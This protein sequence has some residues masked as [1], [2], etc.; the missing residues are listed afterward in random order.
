MAQALRALTLWL[1]VLPVL[2]I[3]FLTGGVGR[4]DAMSAATVELCG[5]L[6]CLA[7]GLAA[8]S[9]VRTRSG[10]LTLAYA[11]AAAAFGAGVFFAAVLCSRPHPGGASLRDLWMEGFALATG[12]GG[13]TILAYGRSYPIAPTMAFYMRS[14]G[15]FQMSYGWS[16]HLVTPALAWRWTQA[17]GC[18]LAASLLTLYVAL[19]L[20][21]AAVERSWRD[22]PPSVRRENWIRRFCTPL[23]QGWF[24]RRMGQALERNPV[25]WLQQYS[26]KAR[27]SKWG[28]CAGL[29]LAES[30][31]ILWPSETNAWR[32]GMQE[33]Y[34]L[35]LALAAVSAAMFTFAGV[36][37][38]LSEK[39][40]GALEL[41]L[42]TPISVN[43]IISGR[44]W[45]LW[46]QFLPAGLTLLLGELAVLS[47]GAT[48]SPH[49]AMGR[50]ESWF[51]TDE[52]LLRL[53]F[54]VNAFV[55]L[56]VFATYA[57]LRLKNLAGAAALTWAGIALVGATFGLVWSTVAAM[58]GELPFPV[59]CGLMT[60]IN[61][62][63]M[64]LAFFLLRHSLSRRIYAF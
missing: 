9:V 63:F 37:G 10:A 16:A 52:W 28:L 60:A 20:G 27:I 15:F 4:S 23:F 29:M 7:A 58:A 8:S 42:V 26:W 49:W 21:A 5:G 24:R 40:N 47:L 25:A 38:F 30:W 55:A 59:V 3:P 1:S 11:L 46:K 36:N 53:F 50:G 35:Q 31:L 56:P 22:K 44:A 17:L 12:S 45:G 34:E 51:V 2:A 14:P 57:A 19:A 18:E 43:K 13:G 6:V 54:C 48:S 39:R 32:A 33:M 41:L 61:G 64:A 62:G